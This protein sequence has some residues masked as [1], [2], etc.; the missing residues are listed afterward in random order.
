MQKTKLPLWLSFLILLAL[1]VPSHIIGIDKFATIDEP[2]WVI[3]GSNYYYALTHGDFANTIYDYHPAVTTTWVVTAGMLTVFPEYRG[4][5]QGYFDVRKPNYDDFMQAHGQQTLDLLRNSRLIQSALLIALAL[6]AFYLLQL[7]LERWIALF[8]VALAFDAPFFLGHSRLINH[9][10]MLT[11]FVTVSVLGAF[12]YFKMGRKLVYLL[13]S[14]AAFGLAQ[15]TKSPSIVLVGIVGLIPFIGLFERGKPFGAKFWDAV[16]MMLIWLGVAALVYVAL[17]PGMWV[18]A[19]KMLYEIYGNAFSYAF[20]GARLDVTQQLEPDSFSLTSGVGGVAL[21]LQVLALRTTPLTWLGL[22]LAI[23][24]LFSRKVK[25]LVK[26]LIG[27]LFLTAA[28]FVLMFGIAKGRDSA[29]YI[30]TSFLDLDLIAA[31]GWGFGLVWLT[32]RWSALDKAWVR[33]VAFGLIVFAQLASGLPHYPYYYT[34]LNPLT[35]P[36]AENAVGYGEGLDQ[37]A[38]YLAQKQDSDGLR[39]FAYSGMGPFS[40]F[41]P[42]KVDVMKKAYFWEAGIPSVISG[43]RWSEYV[44]VYAVVQDKLPECA[45]FIAALQSVKPEHVVTIDGVEYAR[46]YRT[47]DIPESVYTALAK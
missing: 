36:S 16:R 7:L 37:A 28:L 42:G 40:Y 34:Y 33:V 2:W 5:G 30:L 41:F 43:M 22:L 1:T 21:Y 24:A 4:F 46:I 31:L 32:G 27:Y 18:A 9:E 35:P 13:I 44:V 39:V 6:L 23:P 10:G 3:S 47:A 8:A 26:E 14:G 11:M 25:P 15:L 20:Q 45:A 38:T 17:W 12:V 29:H 19:N